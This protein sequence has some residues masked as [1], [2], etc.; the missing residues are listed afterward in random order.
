M[1][2]VGALSAGCASSKPSTSAVNRDVPTATAFS[3]AKPATPSP[4]PPGATATASSTNTKSPT[5]DANQDFE[6]AFTLSDQPGAPDVEFELSV[7]GTKSGLVVSRNAGNDRQ[8]GNLKGDGVVWRDGFHVSASLGVE[9]V[10]SDSSDD[11][12]VFASFVNGLEVSA[13]H[14]RLDPGGALKSSDTRGL[15]Y[16]D[17]VRHGGA[18]YALRTALMS[19]PRSHQIEAAS[20]GA[21]VYRLPVHPRNWRCQ[22][23]FGFEPGGYR[24][25]ALGISKEGDFFVVARGCDELGPHILRWKKPGNPTFTPIDTEVELPLHAKIYPVLNSDS[26]YLV[27]DEVHLLTTNHLSTPVPNPG[28]IRFDRRAAQT[29]DG[30]LWLVGQGEAIDDRTLYRFD[31]KSFTRVDLLDRAKV[32]SVATDPAGN[33]WVATGK[34]L[35]TRMSKIED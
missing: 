16:V 34:V 28:G 25:V 3:A 32:D 20:P 22:D 6:V 27:G 5:S 21:N 17:V 26:H 7:Y 33:L 4:A 10:V 23:R 24:E 19:A 1:G 8:F 15:R 9:A 31:G 13:H 2:L 35:L 30:I 18:N 29:S 12:E 11:F 14:Y